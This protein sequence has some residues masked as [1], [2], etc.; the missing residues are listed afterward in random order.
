MSTTESL[1]HNAAH[2]VPTQKRIKSSLWNNG[3]A[4][5]L[6]ALAALL[7]NSSAYGRKALEQRK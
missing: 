3:A 7:P 5:R 4:P 1:N 2:D 6:H